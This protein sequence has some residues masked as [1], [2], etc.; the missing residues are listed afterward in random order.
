LR[1]DFFAP[2]FLGADLRALVL[3]PVLLRPALFFAE[4]FLAGL[5]LA[6]LFFAELFLAELFFAELFLAVL[7]FAPLFFAGLFFALLFFAVLF[8]APLFFA[9]GT[10][11]PSRRASERPIAIA[12]FLLVTFLP[13]PPLRRVPCLRSCITFSTLSDAFL[14]YVAMCLSSSLD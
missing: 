12:C 10:L 8:L 4:L 1:E 9:G 7:F 6:E 3:R 2:V 5:F 13:E 14:P 11:S